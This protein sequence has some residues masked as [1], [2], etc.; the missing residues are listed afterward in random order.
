MATRSTGGLHKDYKSK[1]YRP[2]SKGAGFHSAYVDY[3]TLKL[4]TSVFLSR[5]CL[6][7]YVDYITLKLNHNHYLYRV[8][9]VPM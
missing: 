1:G 4:F 2:A 9:L 7:T 3:I 8:V 5:N 6:S